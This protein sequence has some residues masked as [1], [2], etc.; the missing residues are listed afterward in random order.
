MSL[1]SSSATSRRACVGNL[2]AAHLGLFGHHIAHHRADVHARAVDF[3]VL[4]H[5]LD[6]NLDL[7]VLQL[8]AHQLTAQLVRFLGD[9]LLFLRGQLRL[10]GL[11]AQQHVN[12]VDRLA[13]RV[14]D[15]VDDA[16]LG[17]HGGARLDLL[18][19]LLLADADAG[20]NQIADD[21][22]HIAPDIADLGELRRLNLDERRIHQLRQ[23]AC[24]FR[25]AHAGGSDHQDVLGH[26]LLAN[27]LGKLCAAITVAQGDRDRTLGVVLTDDIAIQLANDLFWRKFHIRHPPQSRY[28]W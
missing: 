1:P 8:A 20:F 12:G 7:D 15:E 16:I 4:G 6:L 9:A 27:L 21:A 24:D 26:N 18:A 14:Q 25:L 22:L 28:G 11:V 23:T 13:V 5:I 10:L 3:H 2:H 17:K 19:R